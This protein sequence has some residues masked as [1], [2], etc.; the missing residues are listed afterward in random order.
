MRGDATVQSSTSAV[1]VRVNVCFIVVVMRCD[2]KG[3]YCAGMEKKNDSVADDT[4]IHLQPST[5]N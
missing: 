4:L 1:R 5:H 3:K 2:L